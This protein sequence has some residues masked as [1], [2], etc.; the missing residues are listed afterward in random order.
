[1]ERAAPTLD[2]PAVS[3]LLS[4]RLGGRALRVGEIAAR[5]QVAGPH[6]TRHVQVLE[7]R[8]LVRR[9]ADVDDA[10]A[11]LIERT[12]EGAEIG[13]RY[14]STTPGDDRRGLIDCVREREGPGRGEHGRRKMR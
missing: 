13:D 5:M 11:R 4:L 6:V 7:Q 9:L 2:R 1:M 8:G 10:H 14:L 12:S 3:I